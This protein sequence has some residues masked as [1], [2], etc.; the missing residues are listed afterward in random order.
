MP[1]CSRWVA[2]WLRF[3][4]WND[5]RDFKPLYSNLA[6]EDAGELVAKLKES[7]IEYRLSD[8]GADGAGFLRAGCGGAPGDGGAGITEIRTHRIRTVR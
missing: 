2:G 3:P 6:A 7:G 5:E 8:N 1:R 4:S